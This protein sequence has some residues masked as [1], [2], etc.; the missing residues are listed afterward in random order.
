MPGPKPVPDPVDQP[1]MDPQ[2]TSAAFERILRSRYAYPAMLLV[3]FIAFWAVL[4]IRPL[5]RQDWLLENVVVF[6]ALPLFIATAKNLRFSNLAYTLLFVFLCGHEIGAHYTYSMVPYDDGF[7]TLTG[8]SLNALLGFQRNHYDRLLHFLY[9]LLLLPLAAELFEV[10]APPRGVWLFLLPVLF[11]ESHSAIF[12]LIEWWAATV[13]GGDLGQAYLGTQG[14][15]WDAQY[16]MA[17]ALL[18][19]AIAQCVRMWARSRARSD[20]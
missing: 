20:R 15:V 2:M 12:E 16:D 9:G 7:R 5:F 13:F 19:A 10:K 4:A 1:F 6:V 8:H 14:D 11:I 3:L 17:L 18:G